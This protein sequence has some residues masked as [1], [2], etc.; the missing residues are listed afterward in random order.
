V[1]A[2]CYSAAQSRGYIGRRH[3]YAGD[4]QVVTM[5]CCVPGK[6]DMVTQL[7][8]AAEIIPSSQPNAVAT[9]SKTSLAL[10][11][12]TSFASPKGLHEENTQLDQQTASLFTQ[13]LEQAS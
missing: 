5:T 3:G 1:G 13:R 10:N 7:L 6:S 12:G 4:A 11:S 9:V 8:P 2:D